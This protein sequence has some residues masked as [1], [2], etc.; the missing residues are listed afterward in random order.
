MREE[1][2]IK[3]LNLRKNPYAKKNEAAGYNEH[4]YEHGRVF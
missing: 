3:E 4:E 1:Y 2:N